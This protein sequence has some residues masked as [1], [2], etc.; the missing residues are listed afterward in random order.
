[1]AVSGKP[2]PPGKSDGEQRA[3]DFINQGGSVPGEVSEEDGGSELQAF[4]LRVETDLVQQMDEAVKQHRLIR[5]RN[6]WI[7]N[8]II[9]QLE[10]EKQG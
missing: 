2:K 8:A 7:V 6:M 4:T 1:M 10:R 5:S 9:E 3:A